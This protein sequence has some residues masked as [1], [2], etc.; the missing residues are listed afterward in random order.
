LAC[1]TGAWRNWKH[2]ASFHATTMI[3]LPTYLIVACL[4]AGFY[5]RAGTIT[6]RYNP[7]LDI[8]IALAAF[9][10]VLALLV[11]TALALALSIFFPPVT[12]I[13]ICL[14]VLLGGLASQALLAHDNI[15]SVW[16]S[17]LPNWNWFWLANLLDGAAGSITARMTF[18]LLY[19]AMWTAATLCVGSILID[20][21]EVPA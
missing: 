19:G 8:R 13:A 5:T 1:A 9:C 12:T 17:L 10:L 2:N 20:K 15:A 14:I 7:Q 21:V 3:A 16:L 18:A 11:F 4:L 6:L